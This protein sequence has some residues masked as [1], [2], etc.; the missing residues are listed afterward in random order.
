MAALTEDG[1]RERLVERVGVRVRSRAHGLDER[2]AGEGAL[3]VVVGAIIG[4]EYAHLPS[5]TNQSEHVRDMNG[6]M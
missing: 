2:L 4:V 5:S 6:Q 3:G 1:A